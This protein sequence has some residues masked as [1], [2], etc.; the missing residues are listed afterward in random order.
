MQIATIDLETFWDT[1]HSLSKMSPIAYCMSPKTQIISCAIKVNNYPTDVFFGEQRIRKALHALDWSTKMA[2]GHNM[3]GFDSMI[4]AWRLGIKPRMWGCTLAMARPIHS[5]TTGNSLAKLVEHYG[6]GKKDN[7]ALVQ[8]KGKRLEDFTEDELEAMR[9]YNRED[10]EQ[11]YALFQALR[12]H[13]TAAEM[14]HIDATIRMLV[15]PKFLVDH[16]L[17][18]TAQS[19]ERDRKRKSILILARHIKRNDL[20]SDAVNEAE[21]IEALE[22]AVRADLAS[23]PKFSKLLE[24]L[25]VP[26]P[27]KASPTNPDKMVPALAKTDEAFI[28]LQEHDNEIVAAAARARLAVKSTLLETRIQAFLDACDATEGYLPVPLNYCG[29]DTTGR[30]SG[31]AYNPHN[32]PRIDPSKPKVSDALRNCLRAPH[33]YKVVVADQSG[34]EL[35]VNHFLWKV[36]ESM[37]LYTK[38]RK[39]DLYRAFAAVHYGVPPEQV[40]KGQRQLAK[41]AQLGLGF[42]AGWRMFQ[43]VAKLMGGLTLTDDDA[44]AVTLAWRTQYAEIVGGWR[45]CHASLQ[46]IYE[47]VERTI[48][49]WG[50]CTTCKDG[51]RLPSG[52]L[53]RYPGL[54]IEYDANE[55]P[56]WWYGQGRHRARIYA[57]KITENCL[58]EGTLVLTAAGWKSIESVLSTDLV[59]D[60][61]EFVR[62]DGIV[63]KSVQ[64]CVTLDGVFMTPDHEVLTYDGWK[65]AS[66]VQRPYRP[67]IR[68]VDCDAP[69]GFNRQV[70]E[71]A[72]HVPVQPADGKAGVGR[73]QGGQ[74][75]RD[76]KLRL[77]D[78]A[79]HV[80]G[81]HQAR[82]EQAPRVR[83]LAVYGGP[84]P[85]AVAS[86]VRELRR[87]W[88]NG[89]QFL[90]GVVQQ[91]LGGHG[92]LI[93]EGVGIGS[94]RQQRALLTGKLS[95]GGQANQH[96]EQTKLYTSGRCSSAERSDRHRPQHAVQPNPPGLEFGGVDQGTLISK[97]VYDILNCGPRHRFVVKGSTGPMVVHNC[98][99]ALARDTIADNAVAFFKV[100]GFRPSLMVHDELV[101]VLPESEAQAALDT[102]QGIMR[103]PPKWWPELVTESEGDVADTY[104][105]AK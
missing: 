96:D 35:R 105:A 72:V 104:G 70:V 89:V 94:H 92:R 39:A 45:T 90:A 33:G 42:G 14:W 31:W 66:Q 98:V 77:L 11:C 64:P 17:L 84:L 16:S 102:L 83:R 38:D 101:Y 58:A 59:H 12:P 71:V 29:A 32:L 3:S 15:E 26:V 5:K 40:D 49:P 63:F 7:T 85:P 21:T 25:D 57:G 23:A 20:G 69:G 51:I 19:V 22:E 97:P 47:G 87:A 75:G 81:E 103:T 36:Q 8:T 65:E 88:N 76:S 91:L 50:L 82:H 30:W 2:V 27:M 9:T 41:V 37:Q 62:H 61:V 24:S 95:V 6:L 13:Y 68:G 78:Q 1:D 93:P 86:R 18:E 100:T 4:L 10:V 67:D 79:T 43:K 52:R 56:E 28:E 73:D 48:D 53:I 46:D 34:I 99:Q 54:H 44:E 80:Q 74:A 60:G 55:K